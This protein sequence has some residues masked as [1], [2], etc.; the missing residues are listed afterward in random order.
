VSF[1]GS[2]RGDDLRVPSREAGWDRRERFHSGS[3]RETF[4]TQI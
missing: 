3:A 4:L 2:L 1:A